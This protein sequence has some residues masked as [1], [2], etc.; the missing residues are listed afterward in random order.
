MM[1][2]GSGKTT[3][4]QRINAHL[5]AQK[6]PPYVINLDPAVHSTPF[7]SN[8][9][10]RDS[11]DYKEVMKQYVRVM[12]Q[13]DAKATGLMTS[14]TDTTSGRTAASSPPSTYSRQRSTK[15]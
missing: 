11:V 7:E 8:I 9:D 13:T 15:S 12:R 10:I 4:M 3:F 6:Q 5:H 14:T 1:T 2:P